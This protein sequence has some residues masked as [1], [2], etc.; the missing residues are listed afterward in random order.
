MQENATFS[1]NPEKGQVQQVKTFTYFYST[2]KSVLLL[3][4]LTI[5]IYTKLCLVLWV[6]SFDAIYSLGI[7]LVFSMHEVFMKIQLR[8]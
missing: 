4:K 2:I 8:K 7:Y 1:R 5:V 6:R 3:F